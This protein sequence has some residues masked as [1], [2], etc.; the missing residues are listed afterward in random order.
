MKQRFR[1]WSGASDADDQ[2]LDVGEC[3]SGGDCYGDLAGVTSDQT[4]E[5]IDENPGEGG[6]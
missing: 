6:L 5:A 1:L 3:Y 4:P 2:L